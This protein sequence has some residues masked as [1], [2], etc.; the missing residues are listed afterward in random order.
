MYVYVCA[1]TRVHVCM[2]VSA[3]INACSFDILY[4]V[5]NLKVISQAA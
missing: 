3:C 1:C 2:Y 4:I 5:A